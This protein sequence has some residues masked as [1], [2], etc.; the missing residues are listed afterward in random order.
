MIKIQKGILVEYSLAQPQLSLEFDFNP[1]TISRTRN[2]SVTT[3]ETPATRGGYD[4][5]SPLESDRAAHGV[6]MQAETFSI[7]ILLDATDRMNEGDAIA[8]K[9]GVQPEVDTLRAMVEPKVQSGSGVRLLASLGAGETLAVANR[10]YASVVLFVWGQRVLPVFLTS[11]QI[12]EKAHL[13]TLMPYRAEVTIQMQVIESHNPFYKAE[14]IRQSV[15]AARNTMRM[16]S[17][18]LAGTL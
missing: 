8:T 17:E 12:E 16:G 4:F 5:T 6:S 14:V 15:S 18:I 2:V 10:S 1:S 13:P 9:M 7:N 3:G 11:V